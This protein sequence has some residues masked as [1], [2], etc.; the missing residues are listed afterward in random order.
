[1]KALQ[2]EMMERSYLLWSDFNWAEFLRGLDLE[3]NAECVRK[4]PWLR[5]EKTHKFYFQLTTKRFYYGEYSS[6]SQVINYQLGKKVQVKKA[7]M[8]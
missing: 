8:S 4:N 7:P 3:R 1:M 6:Y 5:F 2:K